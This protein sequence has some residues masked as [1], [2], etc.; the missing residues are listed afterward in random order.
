MVESSG[1]R[2]TEENLNYS[3]AAR[4]VA[5]FG[6]RLAERAPQ[7]VGNPR[8]LA[9]AAYAN[10][11]GNGDEA[12][13]DGWRY[14]GRGLLQVTG[15]EDY[16]AHGVA[17]GLPLVDQPELLEQ[18]DAAALSAAQFWAAHGCNQIGRA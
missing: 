17:L 11:L 16:R 3:T 4:I 1:F 14:R 10:R 15:R 5:V 8:A 13:G 6:S 7:L 2:R 9:N 12:S 18:P